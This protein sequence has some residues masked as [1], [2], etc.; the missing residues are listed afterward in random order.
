VRWLNKTLE[1]A[2]LRYCGITLPQDRSGQCPASVGCI[3]H[4]ESWQGDANA[5]PQPLSETPPLPTPQHFSD[6]ATIRP[7][8]FLSFR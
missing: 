3:W 2:G 1:P 5:V 8:A 7:G 4:A 6:M